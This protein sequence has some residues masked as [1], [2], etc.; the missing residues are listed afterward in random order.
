MESTVF[1]PESLMISGSLTKNSEGPGSIQL[2]EQKNGWNNEMWSSM[3][4]N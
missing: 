1:Q 3:D 2:S 4:E